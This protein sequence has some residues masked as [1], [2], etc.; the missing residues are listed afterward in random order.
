M[1]KTFN[2]GECCQG[3]VITAIATEEKVIIIGKEW[4]YSAGSNRNSNQKNAKEFIRIEVSTQDSNAKMTL[5][6]FLN[7]LTTCYY[8]DQVLDW[9]GSQ[10]KLESSFF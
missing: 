7:N 6:N 5:D 10:T 8:A 1:E 2:I 4:D 3:G 9:V